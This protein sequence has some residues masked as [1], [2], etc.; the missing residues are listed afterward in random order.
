MGCFALLVSCSFATADPP[1]L[2]KIRS[3]GFDIIMIDGTHQSLASLVPSDRPAVIEFWA[4][5]CA[6]CRK[7][8][9]TLQK[10]SERH[11]PETLTVLGLTMDHFERDTDKVKMFVKEEGVTFPVAFASEEL[12][13][14]MNE[15]DEVG[16][17]KVLIYD[18]KGKVIEHITSY[19]FLSA[20][21]VKRAVRHAIEK[22]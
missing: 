3:S 2:S 22:K 8:T 20:G 7:L 15:R 6:P 14:F 5:W 13:Q 10:L 21:R 12:F 9:P 18:G 4:T 1:D 11:N 19:S 16:L 17:P